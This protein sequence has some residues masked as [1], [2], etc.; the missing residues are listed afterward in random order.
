VSCYF[1]PWRDGGDWPKMHHILR[2]DTPHLD[3]RE[4][5]RSALV[6]DRQSAK[7][8]EA[9]SPKRFGAGKKHSGAGSGVCSLIR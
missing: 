4:P 5:A 8:S 7:T 3:G 1:D 9:G 2:V 6:I